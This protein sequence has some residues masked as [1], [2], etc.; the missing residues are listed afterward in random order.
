MNPTYPRFG[1][2]TNSDFFEE[3]LLKIYEER[4]K[5]GLTD[6]IGLMGMM[7]IQ[8]ARKDRE[9]YVKELSLMTRYHYATTYEGAGYLVTVMEFD[10]L[11]P[12]L[13]ILTD[14]EEGP[15]YVETM[16]RF[17][18]RGR[19]KP[20]T[21][22]LGEVFWV[23]NIDECEAALRSQGVRF[24]ENPFP[25]L[26]TQVSQ[27]TWNHVAYSEKCED[28]CFLKHGFKTVQ[29]QPDFLNELAAIKEKQVGRGISDL[30]QAVDHLATRILCQDREH[31]ILEFMKSS[32]YYYWGSYLIADQNSS[33]N[34][35]RNGKGIDEYLSPAKV[36]T[37]SET[38]YYLD[39]ITDLPSP[40]EEFVLQYGRRLH[41][42]AHGVRDN[43]PGQS[44]DSVDLV[45]EALQ[46]EGVPF[47]LE[48][49]GSEEEG[50]KQIFSRASKESM[51]V[52]EYVQRFHQYPGFF[53]R[54]N[55]AY[56]TKAAAA[57]YIS[58]D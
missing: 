17:S 38:P 4:D 18:S 44:K 3:N 40:T 47:L 58:T 35:T 19:T 7:L 42:I 5:I 29:E 55:V 54:K 1:D 57:E 11:H 49:I 23:K 41:H 30:L 16:N 39:Y 53:T 32:S 43:L 24:L 51:I 46:K 12:A 50:M 27:Y 26:M 31:A 34:V 8:V 14:L 20:Y 9:A 22:Y 37:A 21:R 10:S 36:F 48:V 33:T 45:V 13:V 28:L 6:N 25:F 56:L 52:T 15:S 2:K